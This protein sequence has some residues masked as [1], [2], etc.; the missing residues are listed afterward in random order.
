MCRATV[1]AGIGIPSSQHHLILKPFGQARM[2]LFAA[3]TK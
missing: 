3:L 1:T 2:I